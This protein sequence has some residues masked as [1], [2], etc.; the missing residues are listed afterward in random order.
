MNFTLALVIIRIRRLHEGRR[1][2]LDKNHHD[3]KALKTKLLQ[4]FLFIKSMRAP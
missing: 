2:N 4:S 1:V 3:I